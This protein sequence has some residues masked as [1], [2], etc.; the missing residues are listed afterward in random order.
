MFYEFKNDLSADEFKLE[1]GVNF[2]F[3]E[4]LHGSFEFITV[5]EGELSVSID[6]AEYTVT[7]ENALLV[8]PNQIHKFTTKTQSR[9]LLCIFST[10]LV[11]AYGKVYHSSLPISNS[12]APP[13][14]LKKRL[15]EC[16]NGASLLDIKGI[17]YSI[18]GE[19]DKGAEYVQK[20]SE[21]DTLLH[22]IF[23]FVEENY[24]RDC[25]LAEL[26][27]ATSYH[28]VYLSK[29]FKKC[30]GT[31]F[32]EYVTRYRISEACYLIKNTEPTILKTAYEC[33]F[34]SLRS[35]NRNFREI[36]GMPP[37]EYKNSI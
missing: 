31:S 3:P 32:T 18:C 11:K 28:Y 13:K 7:P 10:S 27:R 25:S 15:A 1:T 5:T 34:D 29:Y 24:S 23:R 33:G 21:N 26:S 16:N 8:F 17:L 36:I 9:H 20:K 35:F 6:G 37:T 30:V 19:F 2:S 12:F 22:T 4:H 14:E